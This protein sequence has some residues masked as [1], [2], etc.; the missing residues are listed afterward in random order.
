MNTDKPNA[1]YAATELPDGPVK[2][3]GR[4]GFRKGRKEKS[5]SAVLRA[6]LCALCVKKSPRHT[7]LCLRELASLYYGLRRHG[8]RE[9]RRIQL[10]IIRE[11][12][13]EAFSIRVFS[14]FDS[15]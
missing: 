2:R 14:R 9:L 3:R 12:R 5:A 8:F 10:V 6:N 11:I 15:Q 1:A 4:G 13:V 7:N